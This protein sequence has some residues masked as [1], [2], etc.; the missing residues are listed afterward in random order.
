MAD[1]F[2]ALLHYPVV[3]KHG[4]LVTSAVTNMDVHDIAR[5]ART[6]GVRRFYC[7]TPVKTLHAL[8]AK[9][10]DHWQTGFGSTYN[11]TRKDALALVCVATD[12]DEVIIA[13]EREAGRRPF[14]VATSARHGPRRI[15][16]A[17]LRER[18][19]TPGEPVLLVFGTGWGL[20]PAVLDRA[21]ALLEPVIGPTDYNHL[22]VR[23]AAAIILDRL[24]AAR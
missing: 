15:A 23:S 21:D 24:C 10:I 8:V 16:F 9:I 3:D 13:V 5:S 1:L 14:V 17:D 6:Y 12:L 11:E 4:L 22:S 20:A 7:A 18:L 2:L 19:R